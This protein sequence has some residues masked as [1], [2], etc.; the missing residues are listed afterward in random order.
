MSLY[1]VI[2]RSKEKFIQNWGVLCS[3]S[4]INKTN[5]SN[6]HTTLIS[7]EV[8]STEEIKEEL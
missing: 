2:L 7:P 5:D 8:L 4:G 6:S 1:Y 3:N